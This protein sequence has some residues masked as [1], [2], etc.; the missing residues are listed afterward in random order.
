MCVGFF[1]ETYAVYVSEKLSAC[2]NCPESHLS[3][4]S[5]FVGGEGIIALG[6]G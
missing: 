2:L 5:I 3:V 1:L 6:M 4:A